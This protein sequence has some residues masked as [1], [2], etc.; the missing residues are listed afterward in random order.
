MCT[1]DFWC[2]WISRRA[3]VPGLNRRFVAGSA[4]F[5]AVGGLRA[6]FDETDHEYIISLAWLSAL[7]LLPWGLAPSRPFGRVF[8]RSSRD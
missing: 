6:A 7:T 4:G 8:G 5:A 2:L 1:Y 3:T